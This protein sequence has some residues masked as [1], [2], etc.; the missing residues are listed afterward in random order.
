MSGL[1]LNIQPFQGGRVLYGL[2]WVG[3]WSTFYQQPNGLMPEQMATTAEHGF[4]VAS[5]NL[6]NLHNEPFLIKDELPYVEAEK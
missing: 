1:D 2:V 6:T 5:S 4:L 3:D